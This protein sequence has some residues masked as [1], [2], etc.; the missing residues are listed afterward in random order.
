MLAPDILNAKRRRLNHLEHQA[1]QLGIDTP[2]QIA[3][4]IADLQ[5]QI[6]AA[7][8]ASVAESHGILY[9]LVMETRADV[10]R[11]YWLLPLLFVLLLIAVKL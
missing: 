5:A 2:P 9:D 8:P 6:G 3:T 10:R 7:A 11:L 1:A 4:E